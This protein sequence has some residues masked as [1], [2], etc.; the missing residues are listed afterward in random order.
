[1]AE[2]MA[3]VR[4]ELTEL[5]GKMGQMDQVSQMLSELSKNILEM[6]KEMHQISRMRSKQSSDLN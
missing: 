6:K 2:Q 5:K 4:E 3:L 1:M